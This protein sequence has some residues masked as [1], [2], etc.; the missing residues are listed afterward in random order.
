MEGL[1][2]RRNYLELNTPAELAIRNAIAEV[3]NLGCHVDL[4]EAVT[5][6]QNAFDTVADFIDL[7]PS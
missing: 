1:T 5:L 4:T 3:E 6:L 2:P 7:N